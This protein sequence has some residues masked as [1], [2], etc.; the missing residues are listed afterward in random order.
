MPTPGG[1][2]HV[3]QAAGITAGNLAVWVNDGLL[4]DSG[5]TSSTVNPTFQNLTL[6]GLLYE[7]AS[8]GIIAGTTR[9]QAGATVL[10]REVNRVDT[11]TAPGAGSTLGDGVALMA[12]VVGLDIVVTNNTANPIQVYGNGSDTINGVAGAT[13]VPVP[14][15]DVAAFVCGATGA[16][17]FEAG[18]GSF[19]AFP[20]MLAAET[21][22]A[23]NPIA[24]ATATPLAAVINHITV[25]NAAGAAVA[26]PSG[27]YGLELA[28]E[29][30][31][32]NPL[33][34]Y[35]I[36]AGTDTINGLAANA[37]IVIP[38]F[39]TALLRAASGGVWQSDPFLNGAG[40]VP[41][42]GAIQPGSAVT[43]GIRG[44]GNISVITN[45]AGQGNG[46]DTTDDVI[47]TF[48]IPA[49]AFDI[50]G[51][52]V[53]IQ[54]MGKTAATANNKRVRIWWGTTTQTLGLA[55]AG[56]TL[57]ADSGV[58]TTNNGGWNATATVTKYGAA[59]SN[60]QIGQGQVVAG[61][62]HT[63][64][65]VPVLLT[66]TESGVINV[67]VTGASSTTGAAN[68]VLSQMLEVM[69]NN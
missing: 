4:G 63:G 10:T 52:Q 14:P 54:A 41:A 65:Q 39:M 43:G 20:I 22:S 27:R 15:G 66:A 56:G 53:T 44:G 42:T 13:G 45:A 25:V 11:S 48:A 24:Q 34:V 62:S 67:T 8:A 38:G 36:N 60:T 7:S 55:V 6:T 30:A 31:T 23:I 28:V 64:T 58:V 40:A 37:P 35:P 47:A 3:S 9:T 46:A 19:G 69:F 32:A 21:I 2:S 18:V 50:A 29:N 33:T 5:T 17:H 26:L 49:S 59:G 1:S 16:W 68:D 51:R 61:V 57:I 12:S